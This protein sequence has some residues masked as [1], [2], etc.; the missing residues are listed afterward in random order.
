MLVI[1]IIIVFKVIIV[2]SHYCEY[3][4]LVGYRLDWHAPPVIHHSMLNRIDCVR[5][6]FFLPMMR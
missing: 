1:V 2:T 4:T 5:S 3:D 6:V